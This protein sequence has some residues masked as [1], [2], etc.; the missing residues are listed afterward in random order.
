[1]RQIISDP[2]FL[3]GKPYIGGVRLSIELILEELIKF[4]NIRDV[5]KKYP[6]ITE[7]DVITALQYASRVVNAHPEFADIQ[8]EER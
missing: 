1:M 4:R 2:N 8:R 3:H 6:Q 7:D 5:A